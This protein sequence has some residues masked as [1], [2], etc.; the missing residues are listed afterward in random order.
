MKKLLCIIGA[1]GIGGC[2][3]SVVGPS[4]STT[5]GGGG[6]LGRAL[7]QSANDA[8]LA[9]GARNQAL[10]PVADTLG[11]LRNQTVALG[12]AGSMDGFTMLRNDVGQDGLNHV[13]VQQ[14]HGG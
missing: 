6:V 1:I 3:G 10:D 12:L 4:G 5:S 8:P 14:T 11:M 2:S 13:R 9:L 7:V